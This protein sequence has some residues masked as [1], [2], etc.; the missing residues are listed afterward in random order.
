MGVEQLC[1]LAL[2]FEKDFVEQR[3]RVVG[4]QVSF[5]VAIELEIA[6]LVR[7]VPVRSAGDDL[8]VAQNLKRDLLLIFAGRGII[9]VEGFYLAQRN[10]AQP[11]K[12]AGHSIYDIRAPTFFPQQ[13]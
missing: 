11:A 6:L 5:D 9:L 3:F 2:K 10:C 4:V 8:E 13:S 7:D 1:D 12:R